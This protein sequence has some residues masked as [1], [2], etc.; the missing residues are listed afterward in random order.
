MKI[1]VIGQGYVG[2]PLAIQFARSGASVIGLD[3]DDRKIE[4]LK[5]FESYIKHIES[6]TIAEQVKSG[7]LLPSTDFR[8]IAG[9]EAVII[10]VPTP[11]KK[12][13]QPDISYILK[14]GKGIAPHLPHSKR[15]AG[16]FGIDDLSG[17]DGRRF[18]P[19]A[20][21]PVRR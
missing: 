6:S 21:K 11:L 7:R 4:A 9:V 19:R 3:I 18:A 2:L 1:A 5:K 16:G 17:H 8:L 14:T 20:G 10:C 12:N 15:D 13:R